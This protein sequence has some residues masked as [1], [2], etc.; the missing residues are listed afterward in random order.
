MTTMSRMSNRDLRALLMG[1][2]I[3]L[4]AFVAVRGL[5]ALRGW[6]LHE[7]ARAERLAIAVAGVQGGGRALPALRDSVVARRARADGLDS[8]FVS[9]S[10]VA[11]AAAYLAG[12]L[13]ENAEVVGASIGSLQ[14]D[15]A[16]DAFEGARRV[17]ARA[18]V[19]GDIDAIVQFLLL[20]ESGAPLL[21]VREISLSRRDGQAAGSPGIIHANVV[22]EGLV[23][24]RSDEVKGR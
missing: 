7:R 1:G 2:S 20:A 8:L 9:G 15:S 24:P 14:A 13:S 19:T 16:L 5:P 18:S 23:R 12:V 6:T 22:I 10:S 4:L 21:T 3:V 17:R 11:M